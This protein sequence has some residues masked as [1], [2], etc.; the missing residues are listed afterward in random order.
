[1]L[2]CHEN[3]GLGGISR[4]TH[5]CPISCWF[6]TYLIVFF[7]ADSSSSSAFSSWIG[8]HLSG[9]EFGC[10]ECR[11][12]F[13]SM[14]KFESHTLLA[15]ESSGTRPTMI[16]EA[17]VICRKCGKHVLADTECL[18][19]H[20]GK[21]HGGTSLENY[22]ECLRHQGGDQW[23]HDEKLD[24]QCKVV[25]KRFAPEVEREMEK[26]GRDLIE[27]RMEE[28]RNF[29]FDQCQ[30]RCPSCQKVFT[31]WSDMRYHWRLS[32]CPQCR[33]SQSG[34]VIKEVSYQC[35]LCGKESLCDQAIF[36]LH[37]KDYH[38]HSAIKWYKL[39]I[40]GKGSMYR[41]LQMP[42]HALV[43]LEKKEEKI[44]QAKSAI[45]MVTPP[46][47]CKVMPPKTLPD[48]MVTQVIV[49]SLCLFKCTMCKFEH[50]SWARFRLHAEECVGSRE[51]TPSYVKE[52]RYFKC[53]ICAKCMLCDKSIIKQHH[54]VTH[55]ISS[56]NMFLQRCQDEVLKQAL[57]REGRRIKDCLINV[58]RISIKVLQKHQADGFLGSKEGSSKTIHP[59]LDLSGMSR[60]TVI[61]DLCEFN[62]LTCGKHFGSLNDLTYH[63]RKGKSSCSGEKTNLNIETV[64]KSV[65]YEC[66]SCLKLMLCDR[67]VLT[68]HLHKCSGKR[69][70][71][72]EYLAKTGHT[73]VRGTKQL[74]QKLEREEQLKRRIPAVPVLDE[75]TM[76]PTTAI[77][78]HQATFVIADLCRFSCPGCAQS[79]MSHTSLR[80]HTR[81]CHS[82]T[83]R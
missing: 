44:T 66:T 19:R 54:R 24:Q 63:K 15:H 22:F 7:F 40:Q 17:T 32:G 52:A 33:T 1:M 83:G 14:T 25:M 58:G 50:V 45:P 28:V 59:L 8:R 69:M 70:T 77:P 61:D 23:S 12:T 73:Y 79:I 11:E 26:R 75:W 27:R 49:E 41:T 21:D 74:R 51:F 35:L 68:R 5:F 37:L 31:A 42:R 9:C 38:E 47:P 60:S 18:R 46:L 80:T 20:L 29:N 43:K 81:K 64:R 62:C 3:I 4:R 55:E 36:E 78:S 71:R 76:H 39:E 6:V 72:E 2:C 13:T 34:V 57:Q 16:M 30:F 10:P 53:P 56:P 82:V 65:A 48:D 67:L